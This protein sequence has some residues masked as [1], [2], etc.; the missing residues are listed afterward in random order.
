MLQSLLNYDISVSS[1]EESIIVHEKLLALG[2]KCNYPY[3]QYDT[4]YIWIDTNSYEGTYIDSWGGKSQYHKR[5]KLI[6]FF[7]LISM[8]END[9]SSILRKLNA[10]SRIH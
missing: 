6:D 9:R 10:S 3:E 2:A 8:L 4:T 1:K 5:R 7:Q